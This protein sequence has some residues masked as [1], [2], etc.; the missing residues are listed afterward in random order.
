[1]ASDTQHR[2]GFPPADSY[3]T[4]ITATYCIYDAL[5]ATVWVCQLSHEWEGVAWPPFIWPINP[6]RLHT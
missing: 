2:A 3:H 5:C 6:P 1:M 4:F